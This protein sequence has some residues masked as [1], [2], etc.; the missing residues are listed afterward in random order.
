MSCAHGPGCAGSCTSPVE[1]ECGDRRNRRPS[2]PRTVPR[3]TDV[4]EWDTGT[5]PSSTNLTSCPTCSSTSP[6][7]PEP[8]SRHGDAEARF[9]RRVARGARLQQ[10]RDAH[11]RGAQHR[12]RARRAGRGRHAVRHRRHLRR[13]PERGVPR[14]GARVPARRRGRRHQVRRH[15]RRPPRRRAIGVRRVA[16][17]A[18]HRPH[19]PVPGAPARRRGADRGHA[20]RH[21][22][23]GRRRQGARDRLLELRRRRAPTRPPRRRRRRACRRSCRSRTS[24]ACSTGA[25]RTTPS[26]R[27]S[28]TGW[29]SSRTSRWPAACSPAS[30]SGACRRRRAPGSRQLPED[31]AARVFDDRAFDVVERLTAFADERDHTLLELAM[32]WLACLPRMASVIA[33][34]TSRRAGAHERGRRVVAADRRRDGRGRRPQPPLIRRCPA[35]GGAGGRT[36]RGS[37][38]ASR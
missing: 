23:A 34:A 22:R 26:A 10:L 25:S 12:G 36:R 32:S 7:L 17:Q 14:S 2:A 4:I 33:G 19:R 20:R 21:G 24:S 9:A 31:R 18:R 16:R 27:A 3:A 30:S 38:A 6:V 13:H 28:G 35:S 11:R 8:H 37:P 1:G 29:G 15:G 5:R